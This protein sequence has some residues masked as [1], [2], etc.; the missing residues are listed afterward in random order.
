MAM[1]SAVDDEGVLNAAYQPPSQAEVAAEQAEDAAENMDAAELSER[2][3][4]AIADAIDAGGTEEADA[5]AAAALTEANGASN[6]ATDAANL[7]LE[8][9]AV[10]AAMSDPDM[11]PDV[12]DAQA[13]AADAAHQQAEDAQAAAEQDQVDAA[14]NAQE[15]VVQV[16]E[17]QG[18]AQAAIDEAVA[19][20]YTMEEIQAFI[21]A[22][23]AAEEPAAKARRGFFVAPGHPGR[24]RF[25]SS[26][27]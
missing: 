1:L 7:Y 14:A 13:E 10:S 27:V 3:A 20:G 22:Q 9:V 21:A 12:A 26:S 18:V 11:T 19:A 16:G 17:A 2:R 8:S 4:V 24:R 15:L 25:A 23:A 5:A 6:D